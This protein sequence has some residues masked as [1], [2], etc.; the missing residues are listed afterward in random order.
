MPALRRS[1]LS[2]LT[3]VTLAGGG[4]AW[5]SAPA[6]AAS[7]PSAH[8]ARPSGFQPAVRLSGA[9]LVTAADHCAA[10]AADA[11]FTNN[12]YGSGS[13]TTAVAVALAESG[14]NPAAC[15]DNTTGQAC[16]RSTET[17]G[18][19]IDRGAWQLNNQTSDAVSDSCAYSGPC[20]ATDA[21]VSVSV[22][23]TYFQRWVQYTVGSTVNGSCLAY[24]LDRRGAKVRTANCGTS[25]P[26]VWKLAGSTVRTSAGLCLTATSRS[27][28]AAIELARCTRSSLQSWQQRAAGQLYNAGARRCLSDQTP[29]ADGGAAP[30]LPLYT[31]ACTATQGNGWFLP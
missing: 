28:T 4:A 29:V 3:V 17:P 16:T 21:Y 30:G 1:L 24:P 14:C 2:A 26:K 19:S 22:L 7:H 15:H 8:A 12:G 31:A 18:D 9:A 25:A 13:L 27:R 11:G 20:A 5:L 23:G 10:W 6:T